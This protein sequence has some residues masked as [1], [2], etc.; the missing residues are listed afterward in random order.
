MG[1]GVDVEPALPSL[2]DMGIVV[3]LRHS[4]IL[5]FTIAPISLNLRRISKTHIA[6]IPTFR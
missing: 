6:A 1:D 5:P 2:S 4:H 3:T